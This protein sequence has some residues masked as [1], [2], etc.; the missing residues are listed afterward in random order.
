MEWGRPVDEYVF[1]VTAFVWRPDAFLGFRETED[2]RFVLLKAG[3]DGSAEY[4]SIGVWWR[5]SAEQPDSAEPFAALVRSVAD[6]INSPVKAS[7]R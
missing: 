3:D 5:G 1:I 2:T 7:I 4:A 6:D